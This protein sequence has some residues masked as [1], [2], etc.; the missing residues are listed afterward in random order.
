MLLVIF[1]VVLE[2]MA[3]SWTLFVIIPDSF[4]L[5]LIHAYNRMVTGI[6]LIVTRCHV[7]YMFYIKAGVSCMFA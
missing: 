4:I 3:P 7:I 6:K 1:Y 2:D 5:Q